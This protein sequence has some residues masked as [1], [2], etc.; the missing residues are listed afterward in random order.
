MS[1]PKTQSAGCQRSKLYSAARC[2]CSNLQ[3]VSVL[4]QK[5]E[6]CNQRA[7]GSLCILKRTLGSLY[8]SGR[9]ARVEMI[10]STDLWNLDHR[11]ER[12]R[13]GG[14][15]D[16]RIFFERQ[17]RA[18][19]FVV[20]EIAIQDP[21]QSG[22]MENNDVIQAFAPNGTDQALR[23]GVLPRVIAARSGLPECPSISPCHRT[24]LR[25]YHRGRAA[26]N[27]G[28]CPR[29]RLPRAVRLSMTLSG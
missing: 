23:V 20:I 5:G 17:M 14:S 4:P 10:Q 27:A 21:A 12:G 11:T 9:F 7:H 19:S 16:G 25:K 8:R 28:R 26:S 3:R 22:A 15:A 29:G 13:L 1:L 2:A 6:S 24:S 18:A